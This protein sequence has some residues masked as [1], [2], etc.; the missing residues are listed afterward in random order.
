MSKMSDLALQVDELVVQAIE[1]GA[2]TEQQVQTYVNNRLLVSIPL[3]QI[4][5]IIS[6]FYRDD[7]YSQIQ[8][9]D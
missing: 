9:I 7:Y 3:E 4:N 2:Q 5:R 8:T 6:D 1:Y